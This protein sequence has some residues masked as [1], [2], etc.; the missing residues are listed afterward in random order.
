MSIPV[1]RF[2]GRR[3][4]AWRDLEYGL[5]RIRGGAVRGVEVRELERLGMLYRRAASDLALARRDYPGEAITDYLNGLCARAH[6]LLHRGEPLRPSSVATFYAAGIPRAFRAARPYV[7]ASL[8]LSLAGVAAGWLAVALRPDIASTLIPDSLFD[9]MARGE[10]P[11]GEGTGALT[12]SLI[13]QNNIR[14]ALICFAGGALLGLPTALAL[15]A[16]GWT[17][18]TLAAAVHRDGI[19][20]PFWSYIAPHGV[21]ELSIIVIAGATGLMLGDAILRP[22]L[23]RRAEALEV[24]AGR[25]VGL[26]LG[27]ASLLVVAG[28]VEGYVSPSGAAEGLKYGIGAVS[29]VLLYSWLLLG[30]RARGRPPGVSLERTAAA[31]ALAPAP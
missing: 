30:G 5:A 17:L 18:G 14:V 1:E 2:I 9:R 21:I 6:P 26:A 19:D 24:A 23:R 11:A 27:A 22:G 3:Q 20:L 13:I 28:L 4:Q 25:A 29:G 15:L 31:E 7:L 10:V 12:A 16:N 8:A